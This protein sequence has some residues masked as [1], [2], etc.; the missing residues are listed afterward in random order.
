MKSKT[1]VLG[2]LVLALVLS[3]C[4]QRMID[5]SIISSKNV[6]ID[7]AARGSMSE[8]EDWCHWFIFIPW[9]TDFP[10]LVHIF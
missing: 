1:I 10:I 3:G 6:S 4:S 7:T 8:G 5:F 2:I 9:L